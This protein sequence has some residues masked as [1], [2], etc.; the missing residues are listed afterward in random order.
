MK[1]EKIKMRTS[2]YF[3]HAILHEIDHLNGVLFIS[4]VD[5]I[6]NIWKSGEL[7]EYIK[8]HKKYPD[9]IE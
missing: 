2:N 8:L 1:G 3:A 4:L 7:D 5:N 9:I 6:K